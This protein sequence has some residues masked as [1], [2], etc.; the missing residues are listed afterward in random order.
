MPVWTRS[1]TCRHVATPIET[2]P[3]PYP[4]IGGVVR[5]AILNSLLKGSQAMPFI[6]SYCLEYTS[7]ADKIN[8]AE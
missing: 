2:L 8:L 4:L 7:Q 1:D 3:V 5:T 6:L